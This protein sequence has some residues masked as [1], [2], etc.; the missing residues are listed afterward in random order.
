ML[1]INGVGNGITGG[2]EV[3]DPYIYKKNQSE[4]V[5]VACTLSTT[6]AFTKLEL[7]VAC[8]LLELLLACALSTV[9]SLDAC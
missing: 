1:G 8:A 5:G 3:Y 2:F 7:L 4:V 6:A 9:C